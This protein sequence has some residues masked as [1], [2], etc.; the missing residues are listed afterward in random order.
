MCP[1][2]EPV[3]PACWHRA[4]YRGKQEC[5]EVARIASEL[6]GKHPARAAYSN[7]ACETSGSIPL[8]LFVADRPDMA[9][10]LTEASST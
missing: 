5:A 6:P 1:S 7:G 3:P 9:Q 2:Q 4:Y 10:A 8:T